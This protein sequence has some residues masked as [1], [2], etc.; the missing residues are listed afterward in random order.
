[1][2]SYLRVYVFSQLINFDRVLKAKEETVIQLM[3]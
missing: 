1:M 2:K 3:I